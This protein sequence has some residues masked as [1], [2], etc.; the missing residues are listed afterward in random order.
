[1]T[2][3]IVAWLLRDH[4]KVLH[5]DHRARLIELETEVGKHSEEVSH[6]NARLCAE[7]EELRREV[8]HLKGSHAIGQAHAANLRR[9]LAA[10]TADP[11]PRGLAERLSGLQ[12]ANE[13]MGLPPGVEATPEEL[14]AAI[15]AGLAPLI[16]RQADNDRIRELR[17]AGDHEAA[18]AYAEAVVDAKHRAAE[19]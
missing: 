18:C 2:S 11:T 3:R 17:E 1:M 9:Q 5:A 12:A 14:R 10:L 4:I 19:L 15:A 13:A 7:N 8:A 16:Q 6:R